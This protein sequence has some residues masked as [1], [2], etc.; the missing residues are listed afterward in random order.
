MRA[1]MK[2]QTEVLCAA[3]VVWKSVET[4]LGKK[5]NPQPEPAFFC[6]GMGADRLTAETK[7]KLFRRHGA[8][9]YR[10][11]LILLVM[12]GSKEGKKKKRNRCMIIFKPC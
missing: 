4:G 12:Q 9:L 11:H 1:F 2:P 6:V 8:G 3:G 10:E 7:M 5:K